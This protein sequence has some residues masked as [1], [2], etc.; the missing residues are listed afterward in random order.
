MLKLRK[1]LLRDTLFYIIFTLVVLLTIFR[2]SIV[3][4]SIYNTNTKKVEGV[5]KDIHII[6]D[7]VDIT[8]KAKEDLIV[9]YYKKDK[10]QININLGDKILVIGEFT[11]PASLK[12]QYLFNYKKYLERKNIYFKVQ[13]TSIIKLKNNKNIFYEIKKI[14]IKRI[15]NRYL[16]TFILGDKKYLDKD[17][18]RSYQE[19][20]ISHL[21]AI[22]GMHITLLTG[23]LSKLLKKMKISEEQEYFIITIFLIN[24]LIIVGI[25]PSILRGILFYIF[26]TLNK[27]YYFYIKPVNIYLFII[28]LSLLVNPNYLFDIAFQYSYL[29]SLSLI[30]LSS[31]LQ[32]NNYIKSLL[33]V[34]IISFIVSIPITIRNFYQINILSIIYNL[35]YVPLVSIV[36]FPMSLLVIILPKLNIIYN[37]FIITLEKTST[38]F[39]KIN[40]LKLVFIKLPNI[41]YIIYFIIILIYIFKN[42]KEYLYILLILLT[43]HFSIPIIS[44]ND[45][46]DIIDV[47]QGDSI[48]IH[49]NRKNILIDTG[50]D[51]SYSSNK[52]GEIFF[53]TIYPA[54]KS[55]GIKKLD[56][57]IL[58]HGDKDHMGEAKKIV[59]SIDVNKVIFNVGSYNYLEKDLLKTLKKKN[60]RYYKNIENIYI[61][62]TPIYFLNTGVYNNENDNSNVLYFI[63]NNYKFLLMGDASKI[64]EKDILE[65]YNLEDIDF[66][67]I[68]HHGSNTSSSK[69]FIES[70]NPKYNLISVGVDNKFNHPRKEV[71][72]ILSNRKIYR[73]DKEGTIEIIIKKNKYKILTNS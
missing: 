70:I 55:N 37:I 45:Y 46:I 10:E 27:L 22:S 61:G 69:E 53:N 57:L 16:Y 34:S 42:K 7:K 4:K 29:I 3:K 60:I 72:K 11:K 67:K 8:L 21:F 52:D 15:S 38:F 58:S 35:F 59:E 54:L 30:S 31:T 20:G 56:Y 49:L 26:F 24:Y 64:R 65:T 40:T 32:S 12:S 5:V 25:T 71:L 18:I 63:V 50:G 44:N 14:I 48:L 6:D 62:N 13:A 36:I 28:S 51:T 2:L 47:G 23:M 19:N 17:I 1:I 9:T 43:V 73:T 41:V 68:G 33:K 66:L 39:S